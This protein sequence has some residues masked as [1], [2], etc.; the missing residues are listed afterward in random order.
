MRRKIEIGHVDMNL[1]EFTGY[2]CLTGYK[3]MNSAT[4]KY[5]FLVSIGMQW[6]P[7]LNVDVYENESGW[8]YIAPLDTVTDNGIDKV[9]VNID[10]IVYLNSSR[11]KHLTKI[12][13]WKDGV[14][15]TNSVR[16]LSKIE[17]GEFI[18]G[19][20]KTY[21]LMRFYLSAN[22]NSECCPEPNTSDPD[23]YSKYSKMER[24]HREQLIKEGRI[25]LE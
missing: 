20:Q 5:I 22:E 16:F 7:N 19:S 6:A 24:L 9:K 18:G 14:D 2:H 13:V 23:T 1:I 11:Y 17:H 15:V 4:F 8:Y 10:G 21:H 25:K 3:I 12:I